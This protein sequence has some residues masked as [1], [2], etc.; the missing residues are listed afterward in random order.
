[1]KKIIHA[2]ET[3]AEQLK[4]SSKDISQDGWNI[5]EEIDRL[6]ARYPLSYNSSAGKD[7]DKEASEEDIN[8][9]FGRD[10]G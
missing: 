4:N 5:P 3:H 6:K 1:M 10:R 2:L 8:H 7:S 9:L